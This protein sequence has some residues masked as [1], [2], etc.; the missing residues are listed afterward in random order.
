MCR[1]LDLDIPHDRLAPSDVLAG[2][3]EI[4]RDFTMIHLS[5]D[6]WLL[7]LMAGNSEQIAKGRAMLFNTKQVLKRLERKRVSCAPREAINRRNRLIVATVKAAGG[8]GTKI[9]RSRDPGGALLEQMRYED[10]YHRHQTEADFWQQYEANEAAAEA[11]RLADLTDHARARD[12]WRNA[13][14]LSH[15]VTRP[16]APVRSSARTLIRAIA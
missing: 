6:S 8:I 9:V 1:L 3:A 15:L 5:G 2:L 12:V 16:N 7:A 11:E 4:D 10:F 13:H 14:T